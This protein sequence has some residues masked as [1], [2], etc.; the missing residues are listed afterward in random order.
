VH[1]TRLHLLVVAALVAVLAGARD[2]S[3]DDET[4]PFTPFP[5]QATAARATTPSILPRPPPDLTGLLGL[6]VVRLRT[7]IDGAS[8]EDVQPPSLKSVKIGDT[9]STSLTR[10]ALDEALATGL[11]ARGEVSVKREGDGVALVV[12][13]TARKLVQ[14]VRVT[15]HGAP[16][17]REDVL[18]E[19]D[20]VEGGE[21]VGSDLTAQTD[22]ITA[23]FA[24]HGYPN[25]RVT[26]S[27]RATDDP[28]RA[29]VLIDVDVGNER[30][31]ELR[32]FFVEGASRSDVR[33]YVDGYVVHVGDRADESRLATADTELE[34]K[35]R[36]AGWYGASVFHDLGMSSGRVTLRVRLDTGPKTVYRFE[37][38]DNYDS[39]ALTGALSTADDPD[40]TP[41]HLVEKLEAFYAKRG[42]MDANVTFATRGTSADPTHVLAFKI[43]EGRR[44]H[45]T[46]RVYPCLRPR[47]IDKLTG[48]GPR[49]AAAIGVE[50]DSYLEDELPG[51]DFFVNPSAPGLDA[52][53]GGGQGTRPV[54]VELDPDH[55]LV[56]DTYER[57]LQHVQE[58]YRNEGYLHALV[59]PLHVLRATC[60]KHSPPGTCAPLPLP[61]VPT[62]QCTY[63]PTGLPLEVGRLPP[64]YTCTPD[65]AHGVEC[66]PNV[67]LLVTVKLGP[68]TFLYDEAFVGVHALP[69]E[70]VADAAGIT[71]G[72]PVSNTKIEDA[73]RRI[74]ALYKDQGYAFVDV[75]SSLEPSLDSSRAR[76]RF[77]ITEGEQVFV[78]A[79]VVQG[80]EVTRDSVVQRR[81]AL[82]VGHPYRSSEV[83]A[84]Q[85]Q[86]ATLGV[87]SSINVGLQDPYVPQRDKVVVITLIERPTKYVDARG[88]FSTGEGFRGALEF[89]HRNLGGYAIG[90]TLHAEMSYLPDVFIIDPAVAANYDGLSIIDRLARRITASVTIPEVG[91]GP[92]VRM[93]IDGIHIRDLERD[94]TLT[95]ESLVA[96]LI[97]R[98]ARQIQISVGQTAEY[99]SVYLFGGG[100]IAQY[101]SSQA[102]MMS[103]NESLTR[104]LLVPEGDSAAFAER[105]VVT[106]D[107]R[108][109]SFNAHKGT[110]VVTGLELVNSYPVGGATT[111]GDSSTA[112]S[113]AGVGSPGVPS[114]T[115]NYDATGNLTSFT[116]YAPQNQGHFIRY[117]QTVAGYIPL[118]KH[119]TF[120]AEVRFGMNFQLTG[121][122]QTYPDRLFFLGGFDSMR[123][124][125]PY[126]LVPQDTAT[127]IARDIGKPAS[128]NPLTIANIGFRGGDLMINPRFELRFPVRPPI[129]SVIFIDTG[130]VWTQPSNLYDTPFA[131]RVAIG[132]GIRVVTPVGPLVFDY[133]INVTRHDYLAED[134][135]AFN[136]AIGLF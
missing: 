111:V 59:G 96:S 128:A 93:T 23:L 10:R 66:A 40:R 53:I 121:T 60:A 13:V 6:A 91:L 63:D 56:A 2:G 49:S 78:K 89:G 70:R 108:D 112:R 47:E 55:T 7:V 110:L 51:A 98:P 33:R 28:R 9:L 42:F 44:V 52:V 19:A 123:G 64:Q 27:S 73:R 118:G 36:A 77:E 62:D 87:F 135:G 84:T 130:N 12:S 69:E 26:I 133:G 18:H 5:A 38:N 71:L 114:P 125:L 54:P 48:G 58:L 8:W 21:L 105:A 17:D 132:T 65:P 20:L 1:P 80:N 31:I 86:L 109:A 43:A 103:G 14:S 61:P 134:F 24:R 45:V 127:Q 82:R 3:A 136:F 117:T 124:W 129:D 85:Q 97:Y 115:P 95:K 99:N 113:C 67:D 76:V 30:D 34:T 79:I 122:S 131:L 106:W 4:A 11:F 57:A 74:V 72:E 22:R 83:Q 120:A 46:S 92:R 107:R 75:K 102:S 100:T 37:G 41:S 68:R 101:L 15:L 90:L 25:A 32:W 39:D 88:G 94:F 119:V 29:V 116:C 104:L 126:S 16:L 50:I 35:L 81:I